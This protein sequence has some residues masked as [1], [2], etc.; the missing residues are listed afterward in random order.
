MNA[1][2]LEASCA[3]VSLLGHHHLNAGTWTVVDAF[4]IRHQPL[5]CGMWL[6]TTTAFLATALSALPPSYVRAV[7]LLLLT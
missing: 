6:L 7:N 5:R 1:H 3:V 4:G 2:F